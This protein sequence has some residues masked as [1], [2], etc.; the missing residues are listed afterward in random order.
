MEF[1]PL[2]Q[3]AERATI[4]SVVPR[5]MSHCHDSLRPSVVPSRIGTTLLPSSTP[6]TRSFS[7]RRKTSKRLDKTLPQTLKRRR[8]LVSPQLKMRCVFEHRRH[9][10]SAATLHLFFPDGKQNRRPDK[11]RIRCCT[12]R[13]RTC[14][15]RA[16][17]STTTT[18]PQSAARIIRA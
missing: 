4:A 17:S 13:Q 10:F 1:G 3:T 8:R 5:D 7:R 16:A 6:L 11:P 18:R 15:R 2:G 14:Q 9:L 12:I